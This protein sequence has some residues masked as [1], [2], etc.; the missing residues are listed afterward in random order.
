[1]A[2][3]A[4]VDPRE[5]FVDLGEQLAL[6]VADAEQQV[7]V[8]L[9]RRAVSRIRKLLAILAHPV[10]GARRLSEELAPPL[11]EQ[12]AKPIQLSLAHRGMRAPRI[13]HRGAQSQSRPL[14]MRLAYLDAFSGISGDMTLGA[15]VD[16]GFPL[17]ALRDAIATLALPDVTVEAEPIERSGI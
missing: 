4:V 12:P 5:R 3:R 14:T 7:P 11:L 17:D 15:L 1:L 8:A 2:V 6:A 16:L 13:G 10:D 9:E